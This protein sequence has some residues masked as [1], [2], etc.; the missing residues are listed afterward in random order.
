MIGRG[1]LQIGALAWAA[2]GLVVA[3]TALGDVIPDAPVFLVAASVAFP[4]SAALASTALARQRDRTA[5]LLLL[6]SVA[7]PTYFAYVLNLPA[8]LVGLG[9]LLAP[10]RIVD[11]PSGHQARVK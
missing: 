8:L 3:L 10:R 6:V 11:P 9:L 7:T 1:A 2:T 4:L 5:G